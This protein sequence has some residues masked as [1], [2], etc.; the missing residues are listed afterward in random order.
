MTADLA[1]K[2][3]KGCNGVPRSDLDELKEEWRRGVAG[4]CDPVTTEWRT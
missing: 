3:K 4:W 1:E 2:L